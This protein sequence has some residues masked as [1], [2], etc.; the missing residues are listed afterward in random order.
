MAWGLDADA[1]ELMGTISVDIDVD[2]I[3]D[4]LEDSQVFEEARRRRKSTP[5]VSFSTNAEIVSRAITLIRI[6]RVDDGTTLLEREF[7]PRW[8]DKADC[9]AAY[10]LAIALKHG[11]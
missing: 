2:D 11:S 6:G 5:A 8:K 3:I 7:M 9:A 1:G 4:Q 10:A